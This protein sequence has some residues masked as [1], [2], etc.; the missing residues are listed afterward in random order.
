M[1]L[2]KFINFTE[3]KKII[4]KDELVGKL[5]LYSNYLEKYIRDYNKYTNSNINF[6]FSYYHLELNNIFLTTSMLN[7][8][9]S[10]GLIRALCNEFIKI[11]EYFLYNYR[12]NYSSFNFNYDY[13]NYND[14]YKESNKRELYNQDGILSNIYFYIGNV[15]KEIV[16]GSIFEPVE[17]TEFTENDKEIVINCIIN[18]VNNSEI[19]IKFD[20]YKCLHINFRQPQP[21]NNKFSDIYSYD[22]DFIERLQYY[23][24]GAVIIK[25]YTG[26]IIYLPFKK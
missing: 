9:S 14:E 26:N 13:I 5:I 25:N 4:S 10:D 6:S 20:K 24:K 21:P 7:N 18:E 1:K 17:I 16:V 23:F 11:G 22:S 3:G 2:L 19:I 15:I 8:D 12:R